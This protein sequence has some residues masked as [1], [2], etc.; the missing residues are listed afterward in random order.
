M[1]K[2]PLFEVFRDSDNHYKRIKPPTR[3]ALALAALLVLVVAG[4]AWW[5]SA[6]LNKPFMEEELDEHAKSS[7]LRRMAFER[8]SEK[9]SEI[10]GGVERLRE[11]DEKLREMIRLDKEAK[12]AAQG[13]DSEGGARTDPQVLLARMETHAWFVRTL[14]RP[15]RLTVLPGDAMHA[16]YAP[17]PPAF[18]NVPDAWP[19]KGVVSSEFGPRLSPFAGQ[20]EFH[21]GMDIMAPAGSPV[22]APAP[23]RVTF[24]GEDADGTMA[25]VLDHG[26]GY[27][28]TFSHMQR[29][30]AGQGEKVDRGGI[31]GS[32]GQ[33]GRST[34][35]HLHYEV[36]LHGAPVDPRK[37]L[38]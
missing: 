2:P 5:L 7:L 36:R 33:E 12:Q 8:L 22:R 28:T 24:A 30:E 20:E 26:G 3:A 11:G 23:G 27:V 25:V 6:S 15:T 17:A 9:T 38:P 29:L 14:N 34:G 31:I 13:I 4:N 35:P 21:K 1:P 18:G 32:V 10:Q 37:Y 16:L 19:V